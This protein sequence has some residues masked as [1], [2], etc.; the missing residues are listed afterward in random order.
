[1]FKYTFLIGGQS[2][3]YRKLSLYILWSINR[4]YVVIYPLLL[5]EPVLFPELLLE[6]TEMALAIASTAERRSANVFL[7]DLSA[8]E[9]KQHGHLAW[10]S[11]SW[12][13]REINR[14]PAVAQSVG[15][16]TVS[17]RVAGSSPRPDRNME[18]GLLLGEGPVH[19]L[20]CRGALE[21]GTGHLPSPPHSIAP[22]ALYNSCP[23]LLV[24]DSWY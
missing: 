6:T 12:R 23:L 16:R 7:S 11:E 14:L 18:S 24:L 5:E 22:R 13:K 3:L 20:P 21:Q 8:S 2:L 9:M 17:R 1:M 4:V 10:R 19:N 15:A